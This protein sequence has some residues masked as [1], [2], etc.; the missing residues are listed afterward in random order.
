MSEILSAF[1]WRNNSELIN[2]VRKLGFL[3]GN[4]LDATY[5]EGAFWNT[6]SPDAL[7]TNDIKKPAD[8]SYSFLCF[9]VSW[10][11]RFDSVVFDPPY[12]LNGTPSNDK[13]DS[14]YG[15]GGERYTPVSSRLSLISSGALSCL[16]C[17]KESGFLIVKVMDQVSGGR[18]YYQTDLVTNCLL[19][20]ADKVQQFHLLRTPRPQPRGRVQRNSRS[21][22]STL[23]IF[24]K[25]VLV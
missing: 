4:V 20:Y 12:K 3:D 17:V 25:K 9:P 14:N 18:M 19:E 2:D 8:H 16:R 22:F 23:M 10:F 5:G 11:N 15:V 13:V 1:R 24:Q 6:W 21:N 7:T